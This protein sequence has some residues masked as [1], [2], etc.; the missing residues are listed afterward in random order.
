M[1]LDL[2]LCED[3]IVEQELTHKLV[4]V[5]DPEVGVAVKGSTVF[6]CLVHDALDVVHQFRSHVG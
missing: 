1:S 6:D 4:S 3:V 2:L 5:V